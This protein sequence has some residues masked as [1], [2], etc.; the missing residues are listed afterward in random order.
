MYDLIHNILDVPR[1]FRAESKAGNVSDESAASDDGLTD[2]SVFQTFP[3]WI[4]VVDRIP[5]NIRVKVQ[6]V[7]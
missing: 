3:T 7:F 5:T 2:T 1:H 6:V 4:A